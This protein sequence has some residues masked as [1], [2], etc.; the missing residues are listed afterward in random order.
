MSYVQHLGL[1][2]NQIKDYFFMTSIKSQKKI[3]VKIDFI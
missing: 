2:L 1:F 3:F